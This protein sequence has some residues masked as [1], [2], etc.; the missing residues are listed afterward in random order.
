MRVTE[1]I[2]DFGNIQNYIASIRARPSSE[3]YNEDGYVLLRRCA[4]E[5]H[6]LLAQPF[7]T[8]N[9]GKGREDDEGNKVLL[10]R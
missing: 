4:A 1:I 9:M 5:S 6:A 8:V 10:R 2:S 3:E 7:Q